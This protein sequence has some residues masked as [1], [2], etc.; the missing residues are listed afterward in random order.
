MYASAMWIRYAMFMHSQFSVGKKKANRLFYI[1][2][3]AS[4]VCMVVIFLASS[5]TAEDSGELSGSLTRAILGT[6]WNWFAPAGQ[7]MS[8]HLLDLL[9]TILRKA[10][11]LFVF[12]VMGFC[13][14]NAIRQKTAAGWLA[15]WISL[16]W[17]SVYAALDEF[18]QYFVPGRA[19]M[20]QDWLIDTLGALI[21]I[22]AVLLFFRRMEKRK[23][24]SNNHSLK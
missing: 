17:C 5:Q 10:A 19:C 14:I 2:A 15:F 24:Q 12:L 9:E 16:C 3:A 4:L 11:H 21:G 1:W 8:A 6:V 18:H 22:G 20:W 13:T 23:P 7:E